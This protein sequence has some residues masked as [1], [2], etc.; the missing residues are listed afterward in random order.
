MK[1]LCNGMLGKLCKY[2][3]MCGID[4]MYSNEGKKAYILA[5]KEGRIFITRNT[6]LKNLEGVFFVETED[7]KLQLKTIIENFD[8]TNKLTLFSRCIRCNEPLK[9]VLK[10]EIRR[11]IPY[12]TY[13]NFNEF[14]RCPKCLR[15]YWKG[16]HY[17]RMSQEIKKLID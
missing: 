9:E 4:T 17:E 13:K 10:E 5:R 2:M 6:Q 8:L 1:F 12:Y 14:V 16:S 11:L 7:L 15:I 3:R